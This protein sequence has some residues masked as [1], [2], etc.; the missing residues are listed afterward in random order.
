MRKIINNFEGNNEFLKN[1]YFEKNLNPFHRKFAFF[2]MV[3]RIVKNFRKKW[4]KFWY[5]R[6][7]PV[8]L[9]EAINEFWIN[10]DMLDILKI[11]E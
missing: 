10:F 7:V 4:K 2:E 1:W 9:A 11:N 8:K 3:L 5:G 6:K